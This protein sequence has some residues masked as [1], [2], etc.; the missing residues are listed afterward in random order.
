MTATP[1]WWPVVRDAW[2]AGQRLGAVGPGSV[3]DHLD[4][5]RALVEMIDPEVRA[6]LDLGTGAGIPGLALAGLCPDVRWVL[7]DS[8]ARR[9]AVVR[10][11]I[12]SLGWDDRVQAVHARAEDEARRRHGEFDLIVAR[13]FGPPAATAEC[14]APFVRRGGSVLVTEPPTARPAGSPIEEPGASG[15]WPAAG[16]APLGLVVGRRREQPAVQELRAVDEPEA[17]FPRKA[18][19]ARKRPLF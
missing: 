1:E 7:L 2:Q 4:H 6:A 9:I 10:A 19:V 13:L 12:E 8:S 3:E 15:R 11:A 14:A 5:A 17:R 16:L 18:G